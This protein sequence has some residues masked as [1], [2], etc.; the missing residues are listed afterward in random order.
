[1]TQMVDVYIPID[2]RYALVQD[3]A[4]PDRTNGAALSADISGFTPLTE[5]S[6]GHW[7]LG[8]ARRS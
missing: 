4:L 5:V 8:T 6:R 3:A 2:R 7:A 1:M